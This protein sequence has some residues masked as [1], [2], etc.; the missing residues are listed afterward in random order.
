[1]ARGSLED[2]ISVDRDPPWTCFSDLDQ[3]DTFDYLAGMASPIVNSSNV[4]SRI[5]SFNEVRFKITCLSF[6]DLL[7][8][9]FS[10]TN[11]ELE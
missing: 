1:M 4:A 6:T 8:C 2:L 9:L 5:S 10:D 7:V 11:Q 3:M